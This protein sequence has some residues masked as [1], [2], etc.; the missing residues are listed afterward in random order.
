MSIAIRLAWSETRETA[1]M[2]ESIK[3]PLAARIDATAGDDIS[4]K[5]F[6]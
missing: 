5:R 2:G 3:T 6:P 1:I 4:P